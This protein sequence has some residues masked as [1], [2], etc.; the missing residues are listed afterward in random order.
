[1]AILSVRSLA[2]SSLR[3]FPY[4]VEHIEGE[5]HVRLKLRV[6]IY[7]YVYMEHAQFVDVSEVDNG[8]VQ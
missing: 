2:S 1:M 8:G 7:M 3:G 5:G 6:P 4:S